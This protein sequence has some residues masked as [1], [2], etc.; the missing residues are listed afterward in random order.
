MALS[1]EDLGG[2]A[3]VVG[4]G[5]VDLEAGGKGQTYFTPPMAFALLGGGDSLLRVRLVCAMCGRKSCRERQKEISGKKVKKKEM[6]W[7]DHG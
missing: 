3:P 2:K 4:L 1:G 5:D 6:K 7:G